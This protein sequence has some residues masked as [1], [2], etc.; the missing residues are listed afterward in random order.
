MNWATVIVLI[1]VV[2]LVVFAVRGLRRGKSKCAS[3][4]ADCPLRG[5]REARHCEEP[6]AKRGGTKRS[7]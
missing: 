2:T 4:K 6:R 7:I 5:T 3:C 1:V